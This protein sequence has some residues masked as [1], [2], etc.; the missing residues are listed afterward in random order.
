MSSFRGDRSLMLSLLLAGG[1]GVLCIGETAAAPPPPSAPEAGQAPAGLHRLPARL[2]ESTA[3][4]PSYK[5]QQDVVFGEAD[6]VG[7]PMDIFTPVG[8]RNGLAVIDV[9]S[10]AWY[11]D[12]GKIRDHERGQFFQIFCQHG[13][14]VFAIRPGSRSRFSA[15]EMVQ[16]LRKGIHW[17]RDHSAE[18]GI[19]PDHMA[20]CGASAGGHLA[21]LTLVTPDVGKDKKVI[22]PFAAAIIF[23]PPTDFVEWG[24]YPIDYSKDNEWGKLVRSLAVSRS[25][26]LKQPLTKQELAERVRK[27]SPAR[28]VESKLPPMLIIHG[29]TDPLVPLQQSQVFIEKVKAAG[30]DAQLIV[31]QG[32]GHPWPTIHEEV[33][34]MADW[35]DKHLSSTTVPELKSPPAPRKSKSTYEQHQDVVFAEDDGSVMVMD[36]FTPTGPKNG[37]GM[38]DIA[39]GSWHSDRGKIRDHAR[40]RVYDIFCGHG[41][42]VFAMRPGSITKYSI[43]EMVRHLRA[44]T[45]WVRAHAADYGIDPNNLGITGGSA[46]GHLAALTVISTPPD[47]AGKVDQ[48]FKAVGIFFPPTDFLHYR[49]TTADFGKDDRAARMVR[50]LVG[51]NRENTAQKVDPAKLTEMARKISPALLVDR[52]QPPFLVIHGDADPLVP[53]HQS[54]I[55]IEALKKAGGQAELIVK[56]GG[57]HPWLTINEEV[58]VMADWFDKELKAPH[59][60]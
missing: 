43:P 27:I 50:E 56:P 30:G 25:E 28:L 20:I 58:K 22:Q 8:K 36:V 57:G 26:R 7:L 1:A 38:I 33:G 15:P 11:T 14:T 59:A 60:H 34:V 19:D 51:D 53:L 55:L 13:Y 45:R 42:T 17:V 29:D 54:E 44:G 23:F 35:L 46:G 41:Y 31:K 24:G 5:Q 52:K 21:C 47:A 2:V 3:Q 49:G 9:V 16:N 32:G 18:F 40:A 37:L 48:P 6:G 10:G 4:S 12:R 39:S